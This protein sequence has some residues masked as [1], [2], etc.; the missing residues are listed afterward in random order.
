MRVQRMGVQGRRVQSGRAGDEGGA[1]SL[2]DGIDPL[3]GTGCPLGLS[4]LVSPK[5][6]RP[7]SRFP[8]ASQPRH[9]LLGGYWASPFP[10]SGTL[11][12]A[13]PLAILVGL[14]FQQGSADVVDV[15][16][17]RD[18]AGRRLLL[19]LRDRGRRGRDRAVLV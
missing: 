9:L 13:V 1:V 10:S 8:F 16:V 2:G 17:R 4:T 14:S 3:L 11:C 19:L 12:G 18:G 5:P 7:S 6:F 15:V